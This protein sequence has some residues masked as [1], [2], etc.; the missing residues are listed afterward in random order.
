MS[1]QKISELTATTTIG[2]TDLLT[3]VQ[4]GS[5]KKLTGATLK[6]EIK[7]DLV[8]VNPR[9]EG[10]GSPFAITSA[11]NQNYFTTDPCLPAVVLDLPAATV[12]LIYHGVNRDGTSIQ[13][14]A[15]G[16]DNIRMG[17]IISVAGGF[18]KIVNTGDSVSLI[19]VSAGKWTV[20]SG[21]GDLVLETS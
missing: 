19:C 4:S 17:N 6:S 5:N 2:D 13:F 20:I 12:G 7:I 1:D 10:V 21:T 15:D 9:S 14:N 3:S 11:N 18:L 8:T 16:T